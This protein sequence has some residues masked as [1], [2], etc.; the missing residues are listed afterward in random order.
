M[1]ALGD[2]DHRVVAGVTVAVVHHQLGELL[3]VEGMLG[4]EAAIGGAGHGRQE[5]RVPCVATEDFDDQK[6]LV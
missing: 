4:N 1:R 6:A 3:D 5:R 2:Q